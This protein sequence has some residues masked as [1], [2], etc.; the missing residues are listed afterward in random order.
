MR[1]DLRGL[2]ATR[3]SA[4]GDIIF[5]VPSSLCVPLGDYLLS[6]AV[7]LYE[8][9]SACRAVCSTSL[10]YP[11]SEVNGAGFRHTHTVTESASCA[12]PELPAL[13]PSATSQLKVCMT[14][15]TRQ[16]P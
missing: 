11:V 15:L 14:N 1:G 9:W 8:A 7:R 13:R 2:I 5:A 6:S 10:S 16:M 3:E 12:G 4:A